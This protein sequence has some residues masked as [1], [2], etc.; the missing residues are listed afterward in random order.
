[1]RRIAAGRGN[2]RSRQDGFTLL[3]LAIVLAVGMVITTVAIPYLIRKVEIDG[4]L[5]TAKEMQ[6]IQEASKWFFIDNRRW[7][8]GIQQLKAQ[9]FLPASISGN[10]IWGNG[11]AVGSNRRS[12]TVRT[13]I[14]DTVAGA[15]VRSLPNVVTQPV[16]NLTRVLSTIPIP[17]QEASLAGVLANS[18][19]GSWT[20]WTRWVGRPN[21][22]RANCPLD[23][24]LKGYE[25]EWTVN[26]KE[27]RAIQTGPTWAA[28]RYT[29]QGSSCRA[30]AFCGPAPF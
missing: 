2:A 10:N 27:G 16:G 19:V 30:R 18:T 15:L 26:T 4:A 22:A 23:T 25:F 6:S 29:R 12:L 20:N 17:G 13:V 14:P 3:E 8:T 24:I 9:G 5:K 11:Y 1:M 7:P 28:C 21:W